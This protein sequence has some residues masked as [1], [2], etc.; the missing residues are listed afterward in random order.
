MWILKVLGGCF[1]ILVFLVPPAHAVLARVVR[2]GEYGRFLAAELINY[3]SDSLMVLHDGGVR[4]DTLPLHSLAIVD[5][6]RGHKV[7]PHNVVLGT[8]GGALVGA[9]VGVISFG[10]RSK[11]GDLDPRGAIVYLRIGTAVGAGT[12]LTAGCLPV[13]SWERVFVSPGARD[14]LR[15]HRAWP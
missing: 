4:P 2:E 11:S 1:S 3:R 7:S 8:I 15:D 5:I 13:R 6:Y 10:I 9:L 12:G 14:W